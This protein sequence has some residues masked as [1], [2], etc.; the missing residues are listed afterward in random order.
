[1][2]KVK[3]LEIGAAFPGLDG[4]QLSNMRAERNLGCS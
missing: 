4:S 2:L 1:M 3:D